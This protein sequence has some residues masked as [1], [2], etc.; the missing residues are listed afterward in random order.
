MI[1]DGEGT[2]WG[3]GGVDRT[4]VEVDPDIG[5]V[6]GHVCPRLASR[7]IDVDAARTTLKRCNFNLG[8]L[9]GLNLKFRVFSN[10]LFSSSFEVVA[11]C[12]I[13][14]LASRVGIIHTRVKETA[15][16]I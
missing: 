2:P 16:L 15:Q 13:V 6:P 10:L 4:P 8:R 11:A 5:L 12:A 3:P 7:E 1:S 14:L 9:K